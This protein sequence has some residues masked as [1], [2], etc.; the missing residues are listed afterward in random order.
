MINHTIG[1]TTTTIITKREIMTIGT[2]TMTGI[3][4]RDLMKRDKITTENLSIKTDKSQKR[5]LRL[6]KEKK[7]RNIMTI[8]I[9]IRAEDPDHMIRIEIETTVTRTTTRE[10]TTKS[11]ETT[12]TETT[13]SHSKGVNTTKIAKNGST[14]IAT[15]AITRAS[16]IM[17]TK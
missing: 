3:T 10:I 5:V 13:V 12:K 2:E 15:A 4:I 9:K 11:K 17:K 14:T 16:V 7:I 1:I 8:S 6:Y